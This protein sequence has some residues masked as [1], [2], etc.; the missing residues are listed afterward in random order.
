MTRVAQGLEAVRANV[1]ALRA[2]SRRRLTHRRPST[3]QRSRSTSSQRPTSGRS[4]TCELSSACWRR[5]WCLEM[6][7]SG[8]RPRSP[9]SS[10]R[11]LAELQARDATVTAFRSRQVF[12]LTAGAAA[13]VLVV[14]L[15]LPGAASMPVGTSG[16]ALDPPS[17]TSRRR[18]V[19]DLQLDDDIVSL[20]PHV[21]A[22]EPAL[23][24]LAPPEPFRRQ[25][26]R[27]PAPAARRALPAAA[28]HGLRGHRVA[29]RRPRAR[30]RH[31][32]AAVA[33]R[34][35]GGISST[36]PASSSGLPTRTAASSTRSSPRG[37]RSSSST[38]WARS[39]GTPRTRPPPPSG[40]RC[41]RPSWPTRFRA[42]RSPRPS[43]RPADAS[44]SWPP[45]SGTIP[46]GRK[47]SWL[48]RP[49]WPRSSRR[50]SD[51]PLP[52]RRPEPRAPEVQ[53]RT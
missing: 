17:S 52:A 45:R 19:G 42:A 5:M 31:A 12:A 15:L 4:S 21:A 28:D 20:P 27:R 36:R 22:P 48:P 40:R 30:G 7:W 37:I 9:R 46:S 13:A 3:R 18:R 29:L 2:A 33:A 44:A 34:P 38:A 50:S 8:P 23:A 51:R 49:S 14:L 39:P 47:P 25:Q 24:S 53:K 41:C 6:G 26:M 16:R 11:A 32:R 10:R 1:Q 43:S 35:H